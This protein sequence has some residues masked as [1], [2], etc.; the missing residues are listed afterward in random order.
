MLEWIGTAFVVV[1]LTAIASSL[2]WF[3]R[4][5]RSLYDTAL[6]M[7]VS[8]EAERRGVPVNVVDRPQLSSF[9]MPAI[10]DRA[11]ITIAISTGGG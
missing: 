6:A 9:I 10:V 11:P 5:D 8:Q 4:L 2:G 7:R 3:A 1:V